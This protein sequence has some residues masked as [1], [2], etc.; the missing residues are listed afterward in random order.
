MNSMTGYARAEEDI[1]GLRLSVEMKSYNNRYLDI[2]L[3]LPSFLGPLELRIRDYIKGFV[4]RGRVDLLIRMRRGS[5]TVPPSFNKDAFEAYR[6]AFDEMRKLAGIDEEASLSDYAGLDGIFTHE[7]EFDPE[8]LWTRIDPMLRSVGDEF[9]ASR[10]NE[11]AKTAADIAEQLDRIIA[12]F[13]AIRNLAPDIERAVKDN[14]NK[15]FEEVLGEKSDSDRLYAETAVLLVRF[16]IHEEI[17][18][19]DAHIESFK[20]GLT[21]EGRS[22]GKKLDFLSQELNREINT[23]ASKSILLEVSARSVEM[24]DAIENIREQLRNVE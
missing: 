20:Q 16:S 21:L 2:S 23:I 19:L 15:R 24:K 10:R 3:N 4:S 9:E 17:A 22:I 5:D 13:E 8:E 11:G 12:E 6:A 18:R 7:S 1:D 14:L